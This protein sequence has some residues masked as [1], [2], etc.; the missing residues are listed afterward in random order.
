MMSEAEF[1]RVE[2]CTMLLLT[3]TWD[4]LLQ[5][6]SC[7]SVRSGYLLALITKN[8]QTQWYQLT[9]TSLVLFPLPLPQ[10]Y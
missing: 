8:P 3:P 7:P 2:T 1:S 4:T 9:C 5:K 10:L 6:K